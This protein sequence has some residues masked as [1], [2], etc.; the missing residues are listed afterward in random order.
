MNFILKLCLSTLAIMLTAFFL[1]GV[2]ITDNN[3]AVAFLTALVL[4]FF[5]AVLKPIL[6]IFTLPATIF[7]FGLFLVVINAALILLADKLID[8]FQVKS[9]WW[10]VVCSIVLSIITSVLEA[11]N[12]K[13]KE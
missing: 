12:K 8:G 3:I 4:A 6:V 1:P 13:G 5:N 11:F 7:T 10:A 2:E 9:F